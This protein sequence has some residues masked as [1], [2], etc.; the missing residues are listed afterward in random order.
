MGLQDALERTLR[1]VQDLEEAAQTR[2]STLQQAIAGAAIRPF[3]D[4]LAPEYADW[5]DV[6]AYL[7]GIQAHVAE[8]YR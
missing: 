5:P 2:L 6:L 7:A 4:K 8:H 1:Q 3:F